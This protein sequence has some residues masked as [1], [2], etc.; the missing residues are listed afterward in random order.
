M[1]F[2]SNRFSQRKKSLALPPSAIFSKAVVPGGP[3][4]EVRGAGTPKRQKM[5]A[6]SRG[7]LRKVRAGADEQR[8]TEA[9]SMQAGELQK[10][11]ERVTKVLA[12]YAQRTQILER[13]NE[14]LKSELRRVKG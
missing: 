8:T 14:Q 1:P 10:M 5:G 4:T 6:S 11:M 12:G 13:E 3:R 9:S 7:F 2:V